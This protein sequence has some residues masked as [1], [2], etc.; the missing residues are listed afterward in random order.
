[1]DVSYITAEMSDDFARS[2]RLGAE[3]GVSVVSIRSKAWGKAIED[4]SADEVAEARRILAE[5]RMRVGMVL[6]PVGKC[7]ITDDAAVAKHGDILNRTI[8]LAHALGA[9]TIRAFPFRPPNPT[10]F[11]D[12]RFDEY[13]DRV[14]ERWA[15]WA[16]MAGA[17]GVSVCFEWV[18]TTLVLTAEQMRRVVD[19]LG[20]P[21][22][23]GVIWEID[24]SAQAGESPEAGY[25]HIRGLIRDTHI[26]RFDGGATRDEYAT[27]VRLLAADGY[28]GPLTVEHWGGEDETLDGIR[29]V[30]NLR[31]GVVGA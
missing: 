1:M 16:E 2:V 20:E 6:S 17:E 14:V 13:R 22:H 4:L 29:Q 3:A 19:D 31:A 9:D 15:P 7:D 25:P 21:A 27:A 11:T 12:S 23:V 24:V 5:H 28:D 18:G 10:P 30:T 26:K 8:R